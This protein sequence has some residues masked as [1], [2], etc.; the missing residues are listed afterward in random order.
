MTK[1]TVGQSGFNRYQDVIGQFPSL[2]CYNHGL[3]VFPLADDISRDEVIAS[4]KAATAKIISQ[5]PWLG[6]QVIHEGQEPGNSGV[7]KTAPWPIDRPPNTLV[8]V[9]DCTDLCPSYETIATAQAP[10]SM[11]DGRILCPFPGFPLSYREDE[12]GPAPVAAVQAN[13]IR[14][15]VILNFSNQHNMMDASGMFVF[16]ALLATAMCGQDL[17]KEIAAAANLDRAKVIPLLD[18]DEPI[19]D[20]SHLHKPSVPAALPALSASPAK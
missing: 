20:H 10:A 4:L 13:F 15:G 19:R 1:P 5:I 16:M 3:L 7:F 17:P 6:D 2:K 18:P 8:Y 9:K 12:I 14:G 11:L